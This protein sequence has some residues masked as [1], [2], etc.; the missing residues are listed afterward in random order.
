M[1]PGLS[2]YATFFGY[3]HVCYQVFNM[4]IISKY[5]IEKPA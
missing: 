4:S 1:Q 3:K 2:I 5:I